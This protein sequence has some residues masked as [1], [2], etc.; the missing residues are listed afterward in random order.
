MTE[1]VRVLH[2]LRAPVG[3][4][5]RHV[6][7]LAKTQAELGLD[8][9][10]VCDSRTGGER[11][12]TML[13][14]LSDVCRLGITR[15]S[16]ARQPGIGDWLATRKVAK[17]AAE[18]GAHIL[19]GHGAKGGAYA[20]LA[21]RRLRRKRPFPLVIYTPHGGSLHYSPKNPIGRI[22]IAAE[23]WLARMTDAMIFESE[24]AARTYEEM[25]CV[26]PCPARIVHNG[27]YPYEFYE[28]E[29]VDDAADF[30]FVGELRELKGVD[31]FLKA[32]A[33][34]QQDRPRA[35]RDARAV[36]VGV[37]A[38][39]AKFHRLANRLGL[40]KRAIFAGPQPVGIGFARSRCLVVPSRAESLPYVVLEAV[41]ARMPLIAT[42]VGGIPEITAGVPMPL[43][44]P[45][46]VDALAVQ[47]DSFLVDPHA[48]AE[49]AA[50][51]QGVARQRFTVQ[52]MTERITGLYFTLLETEPDA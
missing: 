43:V 34:L 1:A 47:M 25:I 27:L 20:R 38:D 5:F 3:G 4:L 19:H 13:R 24:F 28:V 8:V 52:E 6:H 22:Y 16:M 39:A 35:E 33:K 30:L 40:R 31:V 49:R 21:G 36:I 46:D 32:L 51:L 23:R 42:D 12:E 41:G 37:G 45:G 18:T 15:F 2:C 14:E 11:A 44:P 48:F 9:G 10:I 26:P 29:V 17:I 7:D 50:A